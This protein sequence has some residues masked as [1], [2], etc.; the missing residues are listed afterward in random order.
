MNKILF[1]IIIGMIANTSIADVPNTFVAGEVATAA[2]FNEN[3]I[4]LSN[5]IDEVR[6]SVSSISDEPGN[7]SP[8]GSVIA[9]VNG[10]DMRVSS[11]L[12]GMYNIVTP[13]GK[14]ISVSA[15]GYP[16]STTL[17]YESQD[18]TGQAYLSH[19]QFSEFITKTPGH[20]FAN[21]KISSTVSVVYSNDELGYSSNDTLTKINYRSIDYGSSSIGCYSSTGTYLASKIL[22]NDPEITGI[23]SVPLIISGIG[24]ELSISPTEIGTPSV[25]SF[26]VY[27]NGTKIGTTRSLPNA[28]GPESSIYV[29]LEGDYL[30][31]TIYLYK[32]GTYRGYDDVNTSNLLYLS[33][34][35]TGNAYV[36]VINNGVENFLDTSKISVKLVKNNNSYYELSSEAYRTNSTSGSYRSYSN[37]QCYTNST[38]FSRVAAYKIATL[39]DAPAVPV[40]T[41]P[42]TI[43]GYEEPTPHNL[44]PVAN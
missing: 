18:C 1:I 34:S 37:G 21:P 39:T 43:E 9:K 5:E 40:F 28:N 16:A 7:S 24:S 15:D 29:A 25:G 3:F 41:P 26:N 36:K 4:S 27:A 11:V 6:S 8:D 38:N 13:T 12:L 33:N 30:G 23:D 42:I 10:V 44:L 32:D 20:V 31:S 14:T 19:Y 17:V 2:K 22:P 35:C